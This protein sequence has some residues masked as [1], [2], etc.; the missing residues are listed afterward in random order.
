MDGQ[1]PQPSTLVDS[2]QLPKDLAQVL[3][4]ARSVR[5]AGTVDE[6]L[7]LATG[8]PDADSMTV[9]YALPEGRTVVEAVVARVRNGIVA[10]YM[11]P[12]MRRRDPDSLI[13]G[14]DGPTDKPRYRD[15]YGDDFATVRKDTFEWLATQDLGI[16]CFTT[17]FGNLGANALAVMPINA[18]FF[19]LALAMLQGIIP[20]NRLPEGFKPTVFI[21]VAPPFRHTRFGGK[22]VVVHNRLPGRHEVF[23][24]NLYPGPSA[25]KGVYGTLI[26]KGAKEFL[27]LPELE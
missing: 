20:V 13:I 22:Q 2:L 12:Y 26:R 15:H 25:K 9:E 11:E 6:L 19:G 5:V 23:S 10:N 14:D 8:S 24:Y 16:F 17:G 1:S 18:A 21:L 4:N 7:D 3:R 27:Q